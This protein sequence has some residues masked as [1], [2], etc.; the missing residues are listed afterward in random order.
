MTT[1]PPTSTQTQPEIVSAIPD[2]SEPVLKSSDRRIRTLLAKTTTGKMVLDTSMTELNK[3][4]RRHEDYRQAGE[5]AEMLVDR[6]FKLKSKLREAEL[7]EGKLISDLGNLT[8]LLELLNLDGDEVEKTRGVELGSKVTSDISKYKGLVAEFE[9]TNRETLTFAI[10]KRGDSSQ[11]S[12][13][14]SSRNSSLERRTQVSRLHDHLRPNKVV[15]ED[16]LEVI[17]DMQERYLIWIK[18]V[19]TASGQD[20]KY[21]WDSLMSLL[22]KE[23]AK[24]MKEDPTLKDKLREEWFKKMNLILID[25]FPIQGRRLEHVGL[26]KQ[27]NEL[28]STFMERVFSTMYSSQM[29]TAPPV[30]RALVYITKHLK[31]E[32]MDKTV[33][34]HLVKVM[35]E[36]PN[37]EKE[38]E[39]MTFV[40][41][42]ESD[43]VAK[44]YTD[45]K[46]ERDRLGLQEEG[47]IFH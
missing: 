38:E 2:I 20:L 9:H 47:E 32:G 17:L 33:K 15:W 27:N 11:Q 6:A 44:S 41:A 28:P 10:T 3:M 23:W 16:G 37:M 7:L 12:S 13:A 36:T 31:S 18:E 26:T 45:K 24:R 29:D 25:R 34:E 46:N 35:R 8:L 22:D 39:V 4:A 21:E 1:G 19:T 43:V 30:A 40:Y 14:H 42:L 5:P